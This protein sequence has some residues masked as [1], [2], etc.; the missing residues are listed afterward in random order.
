MRGTEKKWKGQEQKKEFKKYNNGG[1]L[2]TVIVMLSARVRARN[3]ASKTNRKVANASVWLHIAIP[4][5]VEF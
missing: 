4:R 2:M 1:I 3:R 5:V